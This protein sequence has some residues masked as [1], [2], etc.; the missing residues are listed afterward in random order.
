MKTKPTNKIYEIST[1]QDIFDVVTEDNLEVFMKD[2]I[3]TVISYAA[4]KKELSEEEIK[5]IK[6]PSFM[7]IDDGTN[8][9]QI[10]YNGELITG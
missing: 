4:F 5:E 8:D 1:V 3:N 10:K 7:W 9:F 2:L 6:A